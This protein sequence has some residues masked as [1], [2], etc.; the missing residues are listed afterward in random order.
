[1]IVTAGGKNVAPAVLEDRLR[2]HALISQ[3]MVVGDGKPFVAALITLDPEALGPWQERHGK[4]ADA[5]VAA[6]RDDPDLVADVQ[7][8]V[9]DAN[10]AV[11]RAESIR[12]FRILDVDFTQ[13]AGQL[14]VKLGIRRSVLLK[15]FAADIDA[16][17]A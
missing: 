15:D 17:Y 9:D 4:P 2:S 6:L 11:S 7:A 14:T 5:T 1:M 10:Q 8:A 3:C 12:K 16:L 13:E